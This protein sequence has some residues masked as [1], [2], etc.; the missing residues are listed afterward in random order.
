MIDFLRWTGDSEF[1]VPARPDA[2]TESHK[3][4]FQLVPETALLAPLPE[5][6][7]KRFIHALALMH[8]ELEE[9]RSWEQIAMQSAISPYHFHR[10]FSE[11]FNETPGQYLGRL[12]LQ[13]AVNLLFNDEPWSITKIAQYC[14]FSSSQ[15]L[16]K[17]LKRELGLTAKQIRK[18]GYESTPKEMALF[19]N[20]L[21]HPGRLMSLEKTLAQSMPFELIWYPQRG[22]KQL[23]L[24]DPN[25]D[26]VI[27][28]YGE[29]SVCLMSATPVKQ[30]N[31]TW[32]EIEVLIGNWQVDEQE[33]DV[34][35]PEGYYLCSEVYLT[36]DVAYIA[37]L[38]AL[39]NA[40]ERQQLQIDTQGFLIEMIRSIT[41]L[42]EGVSFSFQMPINSEWR[43]PAARICD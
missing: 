17:A 23:K 22:M 26:V 11:L 13:V 8:Q 30:M 35:I 21:A 31:N 1:V 14:G 9:C 16:G 37:A 33:Y 42:E 36:S 24:A 32:S 15:A 43:D 27:D 18:M 2:M 12:R 25:W 7:R 40:V 28:K 19:I 41:Q 3:P 29:K 5:Y 4:P 10:Q 38:E 34:V 6:L 20:K 39:F